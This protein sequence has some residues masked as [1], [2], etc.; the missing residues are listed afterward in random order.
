[1]NGG[2][3]NT[4]VDR[5]FGGETGGRPVS[6]K[7]V[8]I[9]AGRDDVVT[10][11]VGIGGAGS[12]TGT[13]EVST[14]ELEDEVLGCKIF[15]VLYHLDMVLKSPC[16]DDVWAKVDWGCVMAKVERGKAG[17][18]AVSVCEAA[19]ARTIEVAIDTNRYEEVS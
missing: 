7:D 9:A 10:A 1:M 17:T 5:R 12:V 18:E 16:V 8:D 4:G 14:A 2:V 6:G 11:D 15:V 3:E 13:R 19:G